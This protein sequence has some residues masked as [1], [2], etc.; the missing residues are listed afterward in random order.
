M[1]PGKHTIGDLSA[2]PDDVGSLGGFNVDR[3]AG[4]GRGRICA[5]ATG[6]GG[7]DTTEDFEEVC[8]AFELPDTECELLNRGLFPSSGTALES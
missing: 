5:S 6:G 3:G 8:E 4:G 7:G 1:V 2:A